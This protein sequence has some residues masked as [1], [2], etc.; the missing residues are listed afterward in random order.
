MYLEEVRSVYNIIMILLI[1]CFMSTLFLCIARLYGYF[2]KVFLFVFGIILFVN[3]C[4]YESFFVNSMLSKSLLYQNAIAL[5]SCIGYIVCIS[6]I[7]GRC[8]VRY[9]KKKSTNKEEKI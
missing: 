6:F 4:E 1:F 8:F 3:T 7:K 9:I 5:V 2:S